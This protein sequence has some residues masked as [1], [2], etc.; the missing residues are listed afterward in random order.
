MA[1][2]RWLRVKKW[3]KK[4]NS[5]INQDIPLAQDK[6]NHLLPW[7][8]G[9][10]TFM[11]VLMMTSGL[12][13]GNIS[14]LWQNDLTGKV[15]IIIDS[16]SDA[17]ALDEQQ[18]RLQQ[19]QLLIGELE[20]LPEIVSARVI[21]NQE[22]KQLL[23]PWFGE[24]ANVDGLPL[25]TLIDV[26]MVRINAENLE[27]VRARLHQLNPRAVLDDHNVW[28]Q[29]LVR[30]A[31]AFQ[32]VAYL[33]IIVVIITAAIMIIF[34]VR[35]AMSTHAEII[36][37]LH[38]FGAEDNYLLKQF[39]NNIVAATW[40]GA[41][42]GFFIAIFVIIIVRFVAGSAVINWLPL[43]I[44]EIW[45]WPISLLLPIIFVILAIITTR[46]TVQTQLARSMP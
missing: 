28:R 20:L 34:A 27:T 41:L 14:Q 30:L 12:V 4:M 3:L 46:I 43:L 8:V 26:T 11:A 40:L 2:R 13:V 5:K 22:L 33:S 9:F 21:D 32:V 36:E 19:T 31:G 7:I 10:M 17:L 38:L 1:W 6:A 18:A 15:T 44:L 24:S 25:P 39:L 23:V 42:P 37:L 45:Q 16:S 35:A 29:R